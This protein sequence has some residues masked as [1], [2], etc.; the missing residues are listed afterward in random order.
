MQLSVIIVNY[1][2]GKFIDDCIS[3]ALKYPSIKNFEWIIVDNNSSDESKSFLLKKFPFITWIDMNYNAG[4]ARANNAGIKRATCNIVLLL[5]PDTFVINDCI[6]KCLQRF[7]NDDAIACS[8]QLINPDGSPQITGNYFM[9]GGLNHLLP[10]PYLGKLLRTIAFFFKVKKTNVLN[11]SPHENVDWINGA[12]LM[13]KKSAIKNAGLM[14]EDFFLYA[15]E[16]EWCFRL[17]KL[18][19]LVVYG[20]LKIIHLQGEVVNAETGNLEKGY[21][22]LYS[23]R[24]LQLIVSNNLR[25][26]KQYGVMWYLFN[27]LFYFIEIPIFLICG[28]C[29]NIIHFKNPLNDWNLIGKYSKNIFRLI[30]LTPHIISRKKYF[31]KMI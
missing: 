15:E 13:V 10:L 9:K 22:D 12:F 11:T 27:L 25:I 18:G 19:K 1:N 24:G 17:K 31:Y 6:D 4:F 2:A 5:N 16:A 20:N 29:D 30:S 3:S 28:F 8:V 23:K 14:D 21:F 7:I 26:R